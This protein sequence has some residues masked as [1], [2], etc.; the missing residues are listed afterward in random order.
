MKEDATPKQTHPLSDETGADDANLDKTSAAGGGGYRRREFL[1]RIMGAT[2]LSI[3]GV[4]AVSG[5]NGESGAAKTGSE[6]AL[7][8]GALKRRDEAYQVRH[9]AAVFEKGQ[10]LALHPDNGDETLFENKIGSY[11]KGLPH[12]EL[13]E[14]DLSA[15]RQFL[16][17]LSSADPAEFEAIPMI[18]G[19]KLADPQAAYCFEMEGADSHRLGMLPPPAFG[20]AWAAGEMVELYW[21]AL[22]RDVPFIKYNTDPLAAQAAADL[23]AM[24]DFRGPKSDGI[25][26]L[27]TLFRGNTPGDLS[28]PYI[29]QF[30]VRD[31]P[32]GAMTIVQRY[33]TTLAGDDHVTDYGVWL[34]IQNGMPPTTANKF[35]PTPRYLRNGRDLGEFVHRDF[36]YQAFL[37]ACLILL[38]F[39]RAA[40]D[41]TSPYL[42]S[43]IQDGFVTFGAPHILDLVA[44][45]TSA[46]LRAA[47]CQKW[48]VHRRL[49]PE[50]FAGR[51]QN[52]VAGMADYRIPSAISNYY[53]IHTDVFNS[54]AADKVFGKTGAYL[55]PQAYPEGSPLHPSYPSGHAAIAG[56]CVTVLKAFFKESFLIPNPVQANGDGLTLLPVPGPRFTIGGELNKLAANIGLGRDYAGIHWRSDTTESLKLGEAVAI[57]ILQN[58]KTTTNRNF[59]GFSLTKFDGTTVTV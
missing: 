15:Y 37:N 58:V 14:V 27:E 26:T 35:D 23:S 42:A 5:K 36:T 54:K 18:G 11:S 59:A 29:S 38:S 1:G 31:I 47:W 7:P 19:L 57:S 12:N 41:S 9:E 52:R 28:G 34:K 55:L 39:G 21:R 10:P 4:P 2:A 48:L 24:S 53:P 22:M 51:V 20:S 25:V 50:M 16:A 8:K 49:R 40:L 45:V 6:A 17:A 30:L 46:A 44:R 43:A 3:V 33:R 13:G 56:A 32:Y